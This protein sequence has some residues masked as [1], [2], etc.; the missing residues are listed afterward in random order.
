MINTILFGDCVDSMQKIKESG[1][2]V[3]TCITSPPYYGLRAYLPDDHPDKEKEIGQEKTPEEYIQKLVE[4]FRG[5]RDILSDDGT[6]WVNIGDSY[7]GT[8]DKGEHKDPKYE[9]GRNGQVKS[10]TRVL[11]GYKSKDLI[12]IP[13]MLA[14]AL[15]NDGW[16]LRCDIIWDKPNVMPSS[17]TDRPNRSHEYL[18]LLSKNKNYYYDYEAI[19]DPYTEPMNRWG[20][21]DLNPEGESTW[22]V[23]VGQSTYRKRN[24]R[25]NP[26]GRRKRSVWSIPTKPYSGAHFAVMPVA[27]VEPCILAGTKEGDIV[28]DPFIGSGTVAEVALKHNRNYLGCDLNLDYKPLQDIRINTENNKP[29]EL[30]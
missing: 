8:G 11:N 1:T 19:L 26:K 18:F 10:L 29:K 24:M 21:E 13:F 17:V 30:F 22:D 7:C 9:E 14:F 20:G 15:R 23:G 28:F 16:Y 25:P 6:L 27:L 4:V 3:Q 5:V 2:K 12:G